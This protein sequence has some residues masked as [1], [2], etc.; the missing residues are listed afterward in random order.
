MTQFS[1]LLFQKTPIVGILRGYAKEVTLTIVE[2]FYQAGFTT[3]EI[4]MNTPNAIDLIAEIAH[5]Y[6]GQLNVGAGTVLSMDEVK[7]VV[8]A[9]GQF[10][11]S[12]VV[13]IPLIEYCKAQ[14]IPVFPGAYTP[15]EIYQAWNAGARMVK[16]FPARN[17]GPAYIK[18]VLAP[19]NHLELMPTGGVN[20]SNFDNYRKSGAKAFGMGGYLFDKTLI[21][22]K[23][24]I[25]LAV[26]LRKIKAKL[27]A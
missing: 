8:H 12:P 20:D 24:W 9:G 3:I 17:L 4:T 7:A 1:E 27:I 2:V 5:Q 26:H 14:N 25:G 6:K 19:L 13:D 15:T 18:D 22:R 11:V 16:V 23:D 10:I 21:E